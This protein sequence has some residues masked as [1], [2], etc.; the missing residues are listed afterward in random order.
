MIGLCL[1]AILAGMQNERADA[2]AF[3][4]EAVSIASV[5]RPTASLAALLLTAVEA[6]NSARRGDL[7]EAVNGLERA[8]TAADSGR[9]VDLHARTLL[10]L[11]HVRLAL[12]DARRWPRW[13]P[14]RSVYSAVRFGRSNCGVVLAAAPARARGAGR[15]LGL[16]PDAGA[17]PAARSWR[18]ICRFA[19][20]ASASTSPGT[21]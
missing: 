14:C 4:D 7:A 10:E 12:A 18:L 8:E 6:H 9:A 1:R 19:R 21:P 3:A 20:S 11:V 5:E 17:A 15:T 13:S 2:E 16:E